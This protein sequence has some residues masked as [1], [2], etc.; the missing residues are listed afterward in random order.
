MI[1]FFLLVKNFYLAVFLTSFTF[2]K[3]DERDINEKIG[4]TYCVYEYG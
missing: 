4:A 1:L 3:C 2:I